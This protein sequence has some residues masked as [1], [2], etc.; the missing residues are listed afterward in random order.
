[1]I[2][3]AMVMVILAAFVVLLVYAS[4]LWDRVIELEDRLDE[5][6]HGN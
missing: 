1:M 2:R 4:Y 5:S 3:T 6:S